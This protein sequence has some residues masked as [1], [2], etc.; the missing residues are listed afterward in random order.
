MCRR[1]CICDKN[2]WHFYHTSD[3][4]VLHTTSNFVV[5][6][7]EVDVH[8]FVSFI[9]KRCVLKAK[10]KK[11]KK[12]EKIREMHSVSKNVGICFPPQWKYCGMSKCRLLFAISLEQMKHYRL[13]SFWRRYFQWWFFVC[14]NFCR[15][16]MLSAVSFAAD[17]L[18]LPPPNKTKH[19][20]KR[21]QFAFWKSTA[22]FSDDN[23]DLWWDCKDNRGV[24][25]WIFSLQD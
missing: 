9:L 10:K 22:I 12:Q 24:T 20:K 14:E 3:E 6:L 17:A 18:S 16:L 1:T 15:I 21:N 25:T 13:H 23:W 2:R 4:T 19:S 5:V 8:S 7:T 11:K